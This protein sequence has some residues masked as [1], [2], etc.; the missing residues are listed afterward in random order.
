MPTGRSLS[1]HEPYPFRSTYL[2]P[3]SSSPFP[4]T[5]PDSIKTH[6]RIIQPNSHQALKAFKNRTPAISLAGKHKSAHRKQ[7][8]GW[9]LGKS[10]RGKLVCAFRGGQRHFLWMGSSYG[11]FF[12]SLFSYGGEVFLVR[13]EETDNTCIC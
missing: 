1:P 10:G 8:N 5:H 2:Y 9:R 13:E 3:N 11:P 12:L 7:Q 6:P 4:H